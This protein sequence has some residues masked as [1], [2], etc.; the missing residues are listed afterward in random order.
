MTVADD[1]IL[2]LHSNCLEVPHKITTD[3]NLTN[4]LNKIKSESLQLQQTWK[5]RN[6]CDHSRDHNQLGQMGL[7]N[8]LC[9][10]TGKNVK[11][12]DDNTWASAV[13]SVW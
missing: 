9:L 4:Y 11:D 2:E 1:A 10:G 5:V 3:L 8:N 6:L 7:S 12:L 13:Q